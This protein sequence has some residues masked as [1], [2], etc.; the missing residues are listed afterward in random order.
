MKHFTLIFLTLLAFSCDTTKKAPAPLPSSNPAKVETR[1]AATAYT[2]MGNE[3]FWSVQIKDGGI[4][5]RTPEKE[6]VTYPYQ[7]PQQRGGQT[8]FTSKAGNSSIKVLIKEEP[9]TD[10]MSGE[11]FPYTVEATKDGKTYYGC[12]K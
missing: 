7:P 9:C 12:G 4:T 6:P 8:V 2:A 1:Q 3:P 11:K 5:F 10:T